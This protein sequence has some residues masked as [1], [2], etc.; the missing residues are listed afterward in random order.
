M[1]S[2]FSFVLIDLNLICTLPEGGKLCLDAWINQ[3]TYEKDLFIW[4]N[5]QILGVKEIFEKIVL[6]DTSKLRFGSV[7]CL[8]CIKNQY[9][10]NNILGSDTS[11]LRFGSVQNLYLELETRPLTELFRSHVA[12]HTYTQSHTLWL[13]V[14]INAFTQF[15]DS[16]LHTEYWRIFLLNCR[17]YN[18]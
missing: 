17:F 16:D 7:L 6:L 10:N 15:S 14:Q 11:E 5:F 2:N 4:F 18:I 12:A 8:I 3:T 1:C 9:E 13:P